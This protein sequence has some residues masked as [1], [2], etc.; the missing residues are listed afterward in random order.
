[1]FHYA[2]RGKYRSPDSVAEQE[3]VDPETVG[4]FTGVCD[5]NGKQ[6]YEGDVVYIA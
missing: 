1:M 2:E 5:K 4:Q 6:I 3:V